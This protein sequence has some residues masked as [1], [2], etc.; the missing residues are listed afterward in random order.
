MMAFFIPKILI[1]VRA[2]ESCSFLVCHT[3]HIGFWRRIRTGNSRKAEA[4]AV[5]CASIVAENNIV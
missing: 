5:I 3:N 4:I 2:W 1:A